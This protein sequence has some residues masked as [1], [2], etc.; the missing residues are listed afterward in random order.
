[1]GWSED[2]TWKNKVSGIH[3]GLNL[4]AISIVPTALINVALFSV[5]QAGILRVH[6]LLI[7]HLYAKFMLLTIK[8]F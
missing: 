3:I 2:R 1:V 7:A 8:F 4:C 5:L 6:M